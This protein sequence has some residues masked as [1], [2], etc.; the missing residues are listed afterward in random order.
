MKKLSDLRDYITMQSLV[1]VQDPVTG[2]NTD[3]WVTFAS[4]WAKVSPLSAREF[5]AAQATQSR[6]VARIEILYRPGV[7]PSM[8][9]IHGTHTY[10]IEGVLA[11]NKTG[12][13]YLTLPVSEVVR[14]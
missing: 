8:R 9:A 4:M 13:H 2:A 12:K 6:V 3:T 7:V 1:P 5:I 10:N 14:G 11:D